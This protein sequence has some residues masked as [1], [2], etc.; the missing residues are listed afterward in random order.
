MK[1]RSEICRISDDMVM[2][3]RKDLAGPPSGGPARRAAKRIVRRWRSRRRSS[4]R[5]STVAWSRLIE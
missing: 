4:K 5:I 3:L 1:E 2:L